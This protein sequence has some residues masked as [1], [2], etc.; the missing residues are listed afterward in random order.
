MEEIFPAVVVM[1]R[2]LLFTTW[3]SDVANSGFQLIIPDMVNTGN[4]CAKK[5]LKATFLENWLQWY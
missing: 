3:Y 1:L 5:K 2:T 4:L